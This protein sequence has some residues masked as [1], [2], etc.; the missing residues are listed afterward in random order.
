MGDSRLRANPAAEPSLSPSVGGRRSI[1]RIAHSWDPASSIARAITPLGD[2]PE[3]QV[4]SNF[5]ASESKDSLAVTGS[6]LSLQRT[7]STPNLPVAKP[8]IRE[9][10]IKKS[11]NSH[12]GLELFQDEKNQQWLSRVTIGSP[13]WKAGLNPGDRLDYL[14]DVSTAAMT[15][16]VHSS[17]VCAPRILGISCTSS[18]F[19]QSGVHASCLLNPSCVW[20][21]VDGVCPQVRPHNFVGIE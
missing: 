20:A 18:L 13:A 3:D 15:C 7:G 5:A 16:V 14:N 11:G 12:Y 21:L 10:H 2:V 8:S 1:D 6:N 4:T 19:A 17:C 9:L